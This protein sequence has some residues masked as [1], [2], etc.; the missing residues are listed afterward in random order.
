MK[1]YKSLTCIVTVILF[2]VFS[3]G[4]YSQLIVTQAVNAADIDHY[5]MDVLVSGGLYIDNI[6]YVGDIEGFGEFTNG[7][8]TDLAAAGDMGEGVILA[9][10]YASSI[11]GA[12]NGIEMGDYLANNGDPDLQ[13]IISGGST[14]TDA[15]VLI[16][17]FMPTGN[18]LTFDFIFASEE[19]HAFV[20]SSFNDVFGFFVTSLEADGYNYNSENIA[21]VPGTGTA[22]EINTVNNGYFPDYT[23]STGPCT[24]CIYF[25]DNYG[26]ATIVFNAFTT[27]I[28]AH[29]DVEPC[30]KYR[31]KIAVGDAGDQWKDSAVFLKAGSIQTEGVS[32]TFEYTSTLDENNAIEGCSEAVVTFTIAEPPTSDITIHYLLEGNA[33]NG[34]DFPAIPYEVTIPAGQTEVSVTVDPDI[35]GITEGAEQLIFIILDASPC[36]P[37]TLI[38]NII[39]NTE[40]LPSISPDIE[41]CDYE[42]TD[43]TASI[44]GGISPYTYEWDNGLG[45]GTGSSTT[46]TISPGVGNYGTTVYNVTFTDACGAT[47]TESVSVTSNNCECYTPPVTFDIV[48]PLCCGD[49]A[50]INYTGPGIGTASGIDLI[51]PTYSWDIGSATLVSGNLTGAGVTPG[52]LVVSLPGCGSGYDITLTVTNHEGV[53]TCYSSQY[54]ATIV[55]PEPLVISVTGTDPLCA[56][57]CDGT[58]TATGSGGTGTPD[59]SWSN[60]DNTATATGLCGGT[61]YTVTITDDNGCTI[62]GTF[63]PADP[64]ALS[65]SV[66]GSNPLC[67]GSCDGTATA[68]GTGGTGTLDYSW[69]NGD[70]TAT[71]TGLCGG[72]TYTVTITDEN[73]CTITDSFTPAD[74]SD[75]TL[76][77]N[78]VDP[79]CGNNNGEVSVIASGGTPTYTYLWD[80]GETT[81][82]ITGLFAGSY[83]VTVTDVNGCEETATIS[84]SDIGAPAI[85]VDGIDLL[86][87]GDADGEA[88]VTVT[89]G[90]APYDYI[91]N[92]SQTTITATG[93]TAGTYSVTVTDDVG[94]IATGT[95][96]ISEPPELTVSVSGTDPLCAGEC[97]GT[98]TAT[99]S[100]GTGSPDYNWNNQYVTA[101]ITGLCGGTTYNLTVTDDNGCTVTDQFTAVE[102]PALNISVSGTDPLCAGSCDGTATA[103]A[104]G[105]TGAL[106]YLWDNGD[107]IA[108]TTNL[109]GGTTYT[110]TVTDENNCTI[111]DSF[112]PVDP[113]QL[114][115]ST[116]G[117]D[118]TCGDNNG[119]V[120]VVASGG[121]TDYSYLWDDGQTTSTATGLYSG[122]YLVTV[123]DANNCTEISTV[124]INDIGAPSVSLSGTDV[125]CFGGNDGDA[126]ITVSG[127]TSP[128]TY[129]WDPAAGGQT[130]STATDLSAGTY[131]VTVTD[132]IGCTAIGSITINE[133]P[134]L[135]I[136]VNG[137][138]PLCYQS[139]DGTA[140]AISSGGTGILNYLWDNGDNAADAINLCGGTTYTVTVTDENNCTITGTITPVDPP[141]LVL[142]TSG[143]DPTCGDNNGEVSV[144]ATGG[145]PG[146]GYSYQWNTGETLSTATGL[147]AG[148]Y[149]VTVTDENNCTEIATVSISDI[150]APTIVVSGID[151]SCYGGS[152][153]EATVSVSGGESP[154]T[155]LW[156]DQG[157]QTIPTATGLSA[158]DFSIT[159]TDNIGC[160]A[161]GSVTINE[162]PELVLSINGADPLCYQSCDGT[163]TATSSGGTGTLSYFWDNGDNTADATSLCGGTTYTVTVTDEN[164]CTITGTIT[165]VDPPQLTVSVSGTDPLCYQSCDGTASATGSGGSGILSYLWDNGDN[166]ADATSLCGGTT[167]T[168]T[169][170]D[171]NNCTVTDMITPVDP[172]QLTVSVT[173]VDPSCNGY[174]DATAT[175]V[176]T[177][178]TGIISFGWDNGDSTANVADLC[179]GVVYTVTATDENSCTTTGTI[180]LVDPPGMTLT[181]TG[182]D[183][184]C[185]QS[186]D[187]TASAI[188]TGGTGELTYLWDNSAGAV[189]DVNGLCGGITYTVTVTDEQGCTKTDYFIPEDPPELILS[190]TGADVTCYGYTDGSTDLIVTGGTMP[191]SYSWDN[192][193]VSEDLTDIPAGDY[194]VTVTDD[195]NCISVISVT[196]DE[197]EELLTS[198]TGADATCYGYSDGTVDLIISGGTQPY[199]YLWSNGSSVQDLTNIPA[200]DYAVTV[201]DNNNCTSISAIT[202][203]EPE[204]LQTSVTGINVS[205]NGYSDGST[206]LTVSGGTQPYDYVWSNGSSMQD[207]T[208]I[209]AGEYTVTVSDNNNCISTATIIITEPTELL[210]SVTGTDVTCYSFTDGSVDLTVTG[211]TQPW[212]YLWDSGDITEDLDSI[213]AG[214]YSVTVTDANNCT[215]INS[216][217]INQPTEL[218]SAISGTD[219]TC[220]GYSDGTVDLSVTGGTQ[221]YNYLWNNS[222]IT[223]DLNNIPAGDYSVVI[224]DDNGCTIINT[225]T[226][227]QPSEINIDTT[228][229]T[230]ITCYGYDNGVIWISASGGSPPLTYEIPGFSNQTGSFTNL[231]AGSYQITVT[232]LN[233]CQVTVDATIY[234]PSEL[235]LSLEGDSICIGE[236]TYLT[237]VVSGGTPE[238]SYTWNLGGNE[239]T[240]MVSPEVTTNFTVLVAD[241]NGCAANASASVYV[242]PPLAISIYPDDTICSGEGTTIYAN[243]SGGMGEPY[244]LIL[245]GTTEIQTPY[246]VYPTETTVYE[247]CIA[248]NCSTPQA[249]DDI[250]VV[251]MPDPPVTFVA[252]IYEGCEPL[253]VYFSETTLHEGQTYYW[254]FGDGTG[255]SYSSGKNPV[256]TYMNPGIYDVSCTVTSVYGCESTY[257]WEGMITVYPNPIAAFLADPAVTT[258]LEPT[259]Y[260]DNTSSTTYYCFWDFGDGSVSLETDPGHIYSSV[261]TYIV[262][263]IVETEHGCIDSTFMEVEIEDIVTFYAPNAFSPDFNQTNALFSP[264][265]HGI[266]PDNWYMAIFDRWGEKVFETNIYD[267][268]EETGKVNHGWDGTIKG[269]Q[270]GETAA[271]SWLVIYRDI[272]G[273][274]HQKSG[275]VLLIR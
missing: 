176:A 238:Y 10:G 232:D 198:V 167:Y 108:G 33:T 26:G 270:I 14:V 76:T 230:D 143:V 274:E 74:P 183:P 275:L 266:D 44:L 171:E 254:D 252:D 191:Y 188:A 224:T 263:L 137:T 12:Y 218:V 141:Q 244:T 42:S 222:D 52:T 21:L 86:C 104:S 63:I 122:T 125:L 75:I 161:T 146:S 177:G 142:S 111:T 261:G 196:I 217:T 225:I 157:S 241:Q 163:A 4:V 32:S 106:D 249:C 259:I 134:E 1:T 201:T 160:M 145:T 119:E 205:C 17:D 248:D 73:G 40:L 185:Y 264:I 168:I 268:N 127:G 140:T 149:S 31:L 162:P 231:E 117:V 155:Y 103:S 41:I 272:T 197:P 257:T 229:I 51:A 133:P 156:N 72:T 20:N 235:Q 114:V 130:T 65:S 179:A 67:A 112:T 187:G 39:D 271:Y 234:E 71:A 169:V 96:M 84:I 132:N 153:G 207:L 91:W 94:C 124:S 80:N 178:G 180:T 240:I 57:S 131:I 192:S 38:V 83:S 245:N 68:T 87:Y 79:T 18:E 181:V 144:S 97:N 61:T 150:G 170:T 190:V 9:T 89:G 56:G 202:I 66:T 54:T 2:I 78:G 154:Y 101:S 55:V 220:F 242:Y 98:A 6:Q 88:T 102:P 273:A 22:I 123:T 19:Y 260:F 186:C 60:G 189:P 253:T 243:Y 69:S 258:I 237:A 121:T 204:E 5:V 147:Y 221:P 46:N 45:T 219:V 16:F 214:T 135:L 90:T 206:D 24:N 50:T 49:N 193:A 93:L 246:T 148:T 226:I 27:V 81:D 172:P 233:G 105:G 223:E 7:N 158:G 37:D 138:D 113:P 115:L 210:T 116:N 199:N 208:N 251:V 109:C 99:V 216:F 164:N 118:P 195:N 58:A 184:L 203:T 269:R 70:N 43:I 36:S 136:S 228:A 85:T 250:E 48:Q 262:S 209:P 59:Y 247:V 8:A 175:V 100:G 53:V 213:A 129:L 200:G 211:G 239:Q 227:N 182:T 25:V 215:S 265:G 23:L 255:N 139:C 152:D 28:T 128:Y 34:T 120:S 77:T 13:S 267:V 82:D 92:N 29:C 107:N 212:T 256:H 165:P 62:T 151:V 95:I 194:S 166:S 126:S 47:A 11:P 15:S 159:V 236:S 173:G 35:D 30:K 174:C 110:I 64:P 3:P